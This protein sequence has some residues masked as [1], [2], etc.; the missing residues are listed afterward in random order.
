MLENM[1]EVLTM[2]KSSSVLFDTDEKYLDLGTAF[3]KELSSHNLWD[4]RYINEDSVAEFTFDCSWSTKHSE[5]FKPV[6]TSKISI[7]TDMV[8]TNPITAKAESAEV[9][10][11]NE[12]SAVKSKRR[13]T[14]KKTKDMSTNEMVYALEKK[15]REAAA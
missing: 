12:S 15:M 11:V 4:R 5:T 14:V 2:Y 1:T 3:V 6:Q 10:S 7:E 8:K 9:Q 13:K